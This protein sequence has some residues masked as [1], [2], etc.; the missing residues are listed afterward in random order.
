MLAQAF[1]DNW[2]GFTILNK[3]MFEKKEYTK[4]FLQVI[5]PVDLLILD[6]D[7]D[8]LDIYHPMSSLA[9]SLHVVH[10]ASG[11]YQVNSQRKRL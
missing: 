5:P 7:L 2:Q 8:G 1:G 3:A 11:E 9:V 10:G 6:G 4:K